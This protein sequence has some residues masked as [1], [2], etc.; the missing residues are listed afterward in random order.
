M[1]EKYATK[2][3]DVNAIH[4]IVQTI[5][6]RTPPEAHAELE[7]PITME[8]LKRTVKQGKQNKAPG[9]DGICQRIKD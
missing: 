4:E 2:L 7:Q 8:E 1:K 5:K 3:T 9:I 6:V